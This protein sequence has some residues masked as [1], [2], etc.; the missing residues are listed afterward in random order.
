MLAQCYI[1]TLLLFPL[2]EMGRSFL[3]TSAISLLDYSCRSDHL[4]ILI[5]CPP[6]A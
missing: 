6:Y 4:F 1:L 5:R 2:K 3:P